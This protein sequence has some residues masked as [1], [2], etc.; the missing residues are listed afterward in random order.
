MRCLTLAE[1]FHL[2]G[3]EVVFYCT[4]FPG[5]L[6][7][8]VV[9]LGY[10]ITILGK[11]TGPLDQ[12]E[13]A[14]ACSNSTSDLLIIDC[15]RLDHIFERAMRS[16][17]QKIMVID[18][19]ANRQHDCDILLDQNALPDAAHRYDNLVPQHCAKLLGPE[20]AILRIEF[21]LH[22]ET[23]RVRDALRSIL[24]S[25]GGT[26]PLNLTAIAIEAILNVKNASLTADIV[27][28]G[29]H[30]KL[31]QIKQLCSQHP[32]L[33]L[34]IQTK[35]MA[36][37]MSNADLALG[38]GGSTHWERCFLGLGALISTV[39]DNQKASSQYLD[40]LGCCRL[41]GDASS[42][43]AN[44]LTS[45]IERIAGDSQSL[46]EMSERAASLIHPED[47]TNKVIKVINQITGGAIL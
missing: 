21:Y 40:S 26:D 33:T 30:S 43:T 18:D 4:A 3:H 42:L 35:E 41:L 36:Q 17:T 47:G 38:A 15:Y 5:S 13:D 25:Y 27:V 2:L 11:N 44:Q 8:L 16:T 39:A 1:V 32:Q 12:L 20:Y 46:L 19:L 29:N 14:K 31:T 22:R 37:L 45:E 28:G 23:L 6:N 34:H 9:Q 7:G 10:P 24:V